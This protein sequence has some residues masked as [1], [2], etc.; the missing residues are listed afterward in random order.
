[1]CKFERIARIIVGILIIAGVWSFY[2]SWWALLGLIPLIT[3]LIGFCPL[4]AIIGKQSC[5]FKKK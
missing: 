5:P 1:M 2:S 3:G 4:Y